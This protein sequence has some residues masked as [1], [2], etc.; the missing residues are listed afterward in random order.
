MGYIIIIV[1]SKM[2][3]GVKSYY[4]LYFFLDVFEF[5]LLVYGVWH[6]LNNRLLSLFNVPPYFRILLKFIF[7]RYL[8]N[9]DNYLKIDWSYLDTCI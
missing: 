9:R 6:N 4:F 2:K 5:I 1:L 7:S 3:Y 8:C